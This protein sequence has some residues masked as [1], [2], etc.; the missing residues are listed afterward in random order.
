MRERAFHYG[1]TKYGLGMVTTPDDVDQA[2]VVVLFNAGLLHRVEP[3]RL[4]VLICRRL[5]QLG[6]IAVRIDLS[7]K[8]DTPSRTQITNRESVAL[9]WR[10]I[11]ESVEQEFGKRKYVLFGLCSGADNAIKIAANDDD[12]YGLILLDPISRKDRFFKFR[13]LIG[14]LANPYKLRKVHRV[15]WNRMF[16]KRD[17]SMVVPNLRDEPTDKDFEQCCRNLTGRAGRILAFFSCYA[18]KYYNHAGQFSRSIPM[19]G[20]RQICDEQYWPHVD[21]LYAVQVHR[22]R[23]INKIADWAKDLLPQLK[24]CAVARED[25]VRRA[26]LD[27][28]PARVEAAR[29]EGCGTVHLR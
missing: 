24:M 8:G 14:D 26:E 23:L 6:Y 2:P 12:I 19:D 10:Y 16:R 27:G 3:Y 15:L 17:M 13:E 4:N 28:V 18:S 11:K 21:H 22:N 20:L 25:C 7:G 9:D 1:D 29:S 5:A